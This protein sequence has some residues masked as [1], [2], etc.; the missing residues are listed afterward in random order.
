[1]STN[2]LFLANVICPLLSG[3]PLLCFAFYFF[4]ADQGL[5]RQRARLFPVFLLVF[6][7]FILGRP[8]Q[9]SPGTASLAD[10]R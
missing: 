4:Y 5:F 2:A 8:L 3:I 10:H 6:S 7:L 9:A 1:M